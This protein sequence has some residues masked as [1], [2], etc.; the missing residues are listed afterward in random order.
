MSDGGISAIYGIF[1]ARQRE[2]R[3]E[4]TIQQISFTLFPSPS[5][6]IIYLKVAST[7]FF[8]APSVN[9]HKVP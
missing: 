5:L 9:H 7:I 6:V 4:F 2:T 1:S 8:F 3:L